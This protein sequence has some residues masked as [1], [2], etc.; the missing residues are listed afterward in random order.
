[1]RNKITVLAS[2]AAAILSIQETPAV[3][4]GVSPAVTRVVRRIAEKGDWL[5]ATRV[6]SAD[7]M[8]S[9]GSIVKVGSDNC[10]AP[11]ETCLSKCEAG[12]GASCYWL[13]QQLQE[14]GAPS[15]S[16]DALFQRS[17][18]LGVVSGCTNHAAAL[19][20]TKDDAPTQKCTARTFQRGCDYDDPW[21]CTMYAL[22]LSRGEG[23]AKDEALALKVLEKSC[24]YGDSDPACGF[25]KGL[26]Q[27]ILKRRSKKPAPR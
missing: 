12:D 8:P 24:K 13:A 14:N 25:A 7:L 10:Q 22:Q 27:E 1:M 16:Y 11:Y 9:R 21:A 26:R 2:A 23:V 5:A 15:E 3:A 18:K 17:C 20:N 19:L 4:A 6:C